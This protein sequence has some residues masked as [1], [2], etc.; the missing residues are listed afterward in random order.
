T[1]APQQTYVYA[2]IDIRFGPA[3][4]SLRSI[5][6]VPRLTPLPNADSP[7]TVFLGM[8]RDLKTAVFLVSTDVNARGQGKCEPSESDCQAVELKQN[9]DVFLDVRA[10]DGTVTQYELDLVRVTLHETTSK[11]VA[12]SAYARASRAGARWLSQQAHDSARNTDAERPLRIPFRYAA[13]SGVLHI[14]PWMSQRLAHG[15]GA[16]GAVAHAQAVAGPRAS[17]GD[18]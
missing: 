15:H 5:E 18:R 3:A 11:A 16:H 1:P 10:S 2:T 4:K 8:R 14:A 9:Q 12:K 17:I 7:V 6:D 13:G